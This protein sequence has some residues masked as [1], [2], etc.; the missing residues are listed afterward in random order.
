MRS[1]WKPALVAAGVIPEPEITV[2]PRPDRPALRRVK[3]AMPREDGSH[4]LRHAFASVV[5]AA[6]TQARMPSTPADS[7]KSPKRSPL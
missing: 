7:P 3:W 2:I 5:L 4:V 1:N 6:Q